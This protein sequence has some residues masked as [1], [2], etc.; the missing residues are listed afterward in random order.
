MQEGKLTGPFILMPNDVDVYNP[1]EYFDEIKS[2]LKVLHYRITIGYF[3]FSKEKWFLFD[4]GLTEF[5][6]FPNTIYCTSKKWKQY[7]VYAIKFNYLIY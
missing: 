7:F 3:K 4:T 1:T 5:K 2:N 6:R